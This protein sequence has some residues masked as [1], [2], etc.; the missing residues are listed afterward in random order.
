VPQV[1]TLTKDEARRVAWICH[2][3]AVQYARTRPG[4]MAT[5][6][7]GDRCGVCHQEKWTT[8]PRDYDWRDC[9]TK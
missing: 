5:F 2:E 3:C 9:L 1:K 8:Q 4:H 6:H 7:E